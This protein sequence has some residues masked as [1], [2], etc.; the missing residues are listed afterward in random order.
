MVRSP[1][2]SLRLISRLSPASPLPPASSQR[3]SRAGVRQSSTGVAPSM[4]A[5]SPGPGVIPR[6]KAA[7]PWVSAS[8]SRTRWPSMAR[9]AARL[10]AV[11][12]LPTPPLLSITPM[13]RALAGAPSGAMTGSA[14][15][16]V[17]NWRRMASRAAWA[18][19][20][21]SGVGSAGA[22]AGVCRGGAGSAATW[23]AA[24]V[25]AWA[26]CPERAPGRANIPEGRSRRRVWVSTTA[27]ARA[28][29]AWRGWKRRR[30][31]WQVSPR[32]GTVSATSCLTRQKGQMT[33][34]GASG[35]YA[36]SGLVSRAWAR[37]L[38]GPL[39]S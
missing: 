35:A 31:L 13:R 14:G 30:Q 16:S 5:A 25:A 17:R 15:A 20:S 7:C 6:A 3:F 26:C 29:S 34:M 1:P 37:R 4:R 39:A 33:S 36:S 22:G 28:G 24:A 38:W 2:K 23:K 18:A 27:S 21:S 9:A 32:V 8:T 19:C 10:T 12:V 11:V